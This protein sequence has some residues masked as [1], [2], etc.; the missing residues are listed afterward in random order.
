LI[1]NLAALEQTIEQEIKN[2]EQ[3]AQ[4]ALMTPQIRK[5]LDTIRQRCA[6]YIQEYQKAGKYL[7]RGSKGPAEFI[8][9]S[10]DTRK[11]KDSSSKAQELFD[12]MLAQQGFVAL[13]GNSIF[14]TSRLSHAS[15]FGARAYFIFPVDG[16]SHYSYTNRGDLVLDSVTDVGLDQT[17]MDQVVKQFKAALIAYKKTLKGYDKSNVTWI[18]D[19]LKWDPS[20]ALHWLAVR[21]DDQDRDKYKIPDELWNLDISQF[22]SMDEFNKKYEPKHTNLAEALEKGREVYISGVY[23]ALSYQKYKDVVQSVFGIKPEKW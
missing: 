19:R 22:V 14:T 1:G 9:K 16:L 21:K 4:D 7:Y 6:G 5:L 18:Q 8:A 15:G 11:S 12:K 13:R 23:Y 20:Y 17:K 3:Q 10:W 2:L